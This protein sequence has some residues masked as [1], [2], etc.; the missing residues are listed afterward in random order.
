MCKRCEVYGTF[1][2]Y[3]PQYSDL[4]PL[5]KWSG[6]I[7]ILQPSVCLEN[8]PV[9]GSI[10]LEAS[11]SEQTFTPASR[12]GE[13]QFSTRDFELLHE[14][15][16]KSL[17]AAGTGRNQELYR[18]AYKSLAQS[19]CFRPCISVSSNPTQNHFLF[20]IALTVVLMHNRYLGIERPGMSAAIAFHWSQGAALMNAVLSRPIGPAEQD[21]LWASAG[22]LGLL[23]FAC[24]EST[25]AENSWPLKDS[26]VDLEWLKLCQGK[27]EIWKIANPLR[28]DSAFHS[29]VPNFLG[30]PS[31]SYDPQLR[32]L[33]VELLELCNLNGPN[34]Q[35]NNPYL[36]PAC[37]LAQ[38]IDINCDSQTLSLFL[39]F[40][41]RIEEDY[42]R[43]LREKD[44]CALLLLAH[45]YAKM[46]QCR[47]WW[48]WPRTV[49]E[50]QAICKY[51][52]L[53]HGDDHRILN[54]SYSSEA[55]S[56]AQLKLGM[57]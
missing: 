36:G 24:F 1:C 43:L 3:D 23:A 34:L 29:I 41:G 54:A 52:R 50:C 27:R 46:C 40:F 9:F 14:F 18:Q 47:L 49:L 56:A 8:L 15:Q 25:T 6:G 38:T 4:Q 26:P 33:S 48:V 32:K 17:C 31:S 30:E 45:W 53:Y 11:S 57:P 37:F 42:K 7:L 22:M 12:A 13:Y 21:A 10:N 51:L 28:E 2:N 19:V 5:D 39:S 55:I 44:P 16:S 20:H 35:N